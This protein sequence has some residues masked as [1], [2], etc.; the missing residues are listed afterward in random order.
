VIHRSADLGQVG[1]RLDQIPDADADRICLSRLED[2]RALLLPHRVTQE[3]GAAHADRA[4]GATRASV[5]RVHLGHAEIQLPVV[6]VAGAGDAA[7]YVAQIE[8]TVQDAIVRAPWVA[9][10][11]IGSWLLRSRAE[12]PTIREEKEECRK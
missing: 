3:D 10:G 2:W 1:G 7:R 11:V 4:G 12:A 5:G 9:G 8:I 6:H